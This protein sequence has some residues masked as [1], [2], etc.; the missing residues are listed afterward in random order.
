MSSANDTVVMAAAADE[1]RTLISVDLDF[2]RLLA[3]AAATRPSL[4]VFRA[5]NL[6][7]GQ[8]IDLMARVLDSVTD[9]ELMRSVTVVTEAAIRIAPL[10]LRPH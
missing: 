4:I 6:S 8:M 3:L 1:S 10:P 9:A 7:D 2:P 5:G